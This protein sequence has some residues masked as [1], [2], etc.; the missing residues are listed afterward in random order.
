MLT[1]VLAVG[2]L[3]ATAASAA[4][5]TSLGLRVYGNR[6]LDGAG[7]PVSLA[8]VNRSGAEYA[9]AQGWGIFDG[10]VDDASIA[11]I[12]SW[13]VNV[14]RIPLNEDCWLGINGV[15]PEYGGA[16]Y[17]SAIRDYVDRLLTH[18]LDVILDL[19]WA[20][21]GTQ[22][23]LAQEEAPDADHAPAFWSSVA[24]QYKGVAGIAYDLFNEP[25]DITWSCWLDGCLT[26][27]GYQAVGE[28]QLINAVR[29]GGATQPVIVEG[30]D[31]GSDLS[32]WLATRPTDP[33]QQLIA[34]WHNYNFGSC[35]DVVCWN[36]MVAPFASQV[37]VLA[38][39]VGENDCTGSY[40]SRLLPWADDHDVGYLAWAW[41]AA[42]CEDGPSLISDYAGTPTAY[43]AW[44][45]QH[46]ASRPA[47]VPPPPPT[48]PPTRPP[49]PH[50]RFDFENATTQGWALRWGTQLA[51]ANESPIAWTGSHGLSLTVAGS[52]SPAAGVTTNLTGIR[53]R[54]IV[55][56][57]VWAPAGVSVGVS[58]ILIDSARHK[59]VIGNQTLKSGWNTVTFTVPKTISHL[60]MLA[61][62]INDRHG[63][64]GRLVLDTVSSRAP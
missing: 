27:Q 17:Q 19:H 1:L 45:N 51:V 34:G 20:A 8:G 16:N 12:A 56:Y 31:W 46:L 44:Y 9:C 24:A 3:S 25:H 7:N 18:G 60:H 6:L 43:G 21:P 63:W 42:S 28:Q 35:I 36:Y 32:G 38:T 22:L 62:Q 53:P 57:H 41:D 55:T 37:P 30:L 59:V 61:V 58:S 13:H 50:A 10:P 11:A 29:S 54:V 48:P 2:L 40:L 15:N 49:D 5:A 4:A 64:R 52:G 47:P 39:E 23:A 14:V 26:P 33:A